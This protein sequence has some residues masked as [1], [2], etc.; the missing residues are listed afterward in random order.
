MATQPEIII[1]FYGEKSNYGIFSNFYRFPKP[2]KYTIG[3]GKGKNLVIE[4][5]DSETAIM[6]EKASLM[7]DKKIFEQLKI[8][9]YPSYSKKLGR[10]VSNWNQKLWD[11]NIENI[12]L[13]VLTVKFTSFPQFKQLLVKT[14]NA[15]LVEASPHDRIW[16]IGMKYNDSN[17]R[18]PDRW[19][20]QN[21]LGFTLM[22]VRENI[23]H[24]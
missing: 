21:I 6:L 10:E 17:I 4:I 23:S 19:K 13:Y 7:G 14:K 12:A 9:K 24:I 22:K 20:G 1:P 5:H 2:I 18:N 3:F 8:S 16:G 15:I 11:E